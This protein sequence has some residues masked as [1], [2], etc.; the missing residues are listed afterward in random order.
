MQERGTLGN[1][2]PPPSVNESEA[3]DVRTGHHVGEDSH[4]KDATSR[5]QSNKESFIET[6]ILLVKTNHFNVSGTI[7]QKN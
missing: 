3:Q 2:T 1:A 7:I 6:E 5:L 4:A